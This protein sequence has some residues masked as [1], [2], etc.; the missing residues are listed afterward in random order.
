MLKATHMHCIARLFGSI[1]STS[2]ISN[3]LLLLNQEVEVPYKNQKGNGDQLFEDNG[4]SSL[5]E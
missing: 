2:A 1:E 3:N 5:I 4:K